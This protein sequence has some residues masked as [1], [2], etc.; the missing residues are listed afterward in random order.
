MTSKYHRT[1]VIPRYHGEGKWYAAGG[2]VNCPY[3]G[4]VV[5]FRESNIQYRAMTGQYDA[6]GYK[7]PHF[8]GL[9]HPR[10]HSVMQAAFHQL[11]ND[12]YGRG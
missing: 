8:I 10:S 5:S 6:Y 1:F 12:I 9:V 11:G 7:C 2:E 3:C 4:A